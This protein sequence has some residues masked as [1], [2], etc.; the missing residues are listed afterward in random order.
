[1]R[2]TGVATITQLIQIIYSSRPFGYDEAML[3][4]ILLDARRCNERGN[5]TGALVCRQD[6][7]LQLLE[8]PVA[9]VQATCERIKRDDRH[10]EM[11]V[12]LTENVA[13]RMFGDWAMFHD[14]AQTWIWSAK[15]ISGGA[16]DRASVEEFKTVFE[17]IAAKAR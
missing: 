7:Y 8:G 9:A 4:G 1:M 15:D 5:V 11:T 12:R 13:E 3:N 14:P 17:T 6:V 16:L 2:L 10:V